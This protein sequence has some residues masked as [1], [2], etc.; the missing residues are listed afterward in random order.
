M[1]NEKVKKCPFKNGDFPPHTDI[2][3][4]VSSASDAAAALGEI[5]VR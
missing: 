1:Q 4:I 2:Y 3:E 5:S